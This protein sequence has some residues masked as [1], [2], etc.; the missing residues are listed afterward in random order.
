MG[1]YKTN[2]G[3]EM[4]CRHHVPKSEEKCVICMSGLYDEHII[5]CGHS[6]HTKCI[7]KWMKR[8]NTCPI[9]RKNIINNVDTTLLEL[10]N[11]YGNV[12][13]EFVIDIDVLSNSIDRFEIV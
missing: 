1:I 4:F 2:E 7:H 13:I 9:C 11:Q 10:L 3:V 8:H 12:I 6:F 5:P